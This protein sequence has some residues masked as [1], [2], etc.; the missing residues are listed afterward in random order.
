MDK[1]SK[2]F[3]VDMFIIFKVNRINVWC[4]NNIFLISSSFYKVHLGLFWCTDLVLL[5]IDYCAPLFI[6]LFKVIEKYLN[7][8]G[9]GLKIVDVWQVEREKEVI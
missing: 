4:K 9:Q 7:A 8:T 1:K 2:D 5:D 6:C 3:K